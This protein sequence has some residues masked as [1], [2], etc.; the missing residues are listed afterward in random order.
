MKGVANMRIHTYLSGF[1]IGQ[2]ILTYKV[3]MWASNTYAID[4]F[5]FI[6]FSITKTRPYNFDLLKPHFYIVKLGF[7]WVYFFYFCSKYILLVLVGTASPRRFERVPQSVLSRGEAVLTSATIYILSRNMKKISV[8][9][10]KFSV[11]FR[12]HFLYIWIGVFS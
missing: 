10:W 3:I 6:R 7:T 11:F 9:I 2:Y 1:S 4:D 5:L 8:F 12:W